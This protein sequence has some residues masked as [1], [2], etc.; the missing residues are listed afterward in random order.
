MHPGYG[1]LSE[2][3]GFARAV[4][5]KGVVFVG[6]PPDVLDALGDKI[7]ARSVALAVDVQPVPGTNEPIAI[8]TAEGSHTLAASRHRSATRWW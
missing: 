2:K 5:A 1:F 4:L 6:P 7:K 8:D 3:S